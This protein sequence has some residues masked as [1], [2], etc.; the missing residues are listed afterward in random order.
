MLS[1]LWGEQCQHRDGGPGRAASP[2]AA[3][4]LGQEGKG[5]SLWDHSTMKEDAEMH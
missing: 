2:W 1:P 4:S 3:K 5:R